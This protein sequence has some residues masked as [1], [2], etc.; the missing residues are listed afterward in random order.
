[1][2]RKYL[3][4]GFCMDTELPLMLERHVAE[5]VPVFGVWLDDV[6]RT[7]FVAK[8]AGGRVMSLQE[9][10]CLPRGPKGDGLLAVRQWG[11]RSSGHGLLH[12]KVTS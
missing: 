5:G 6:S 9:R 4:S 1:M 3:N 10:Q 7:L 12:Q 11:W 2:S 8:L